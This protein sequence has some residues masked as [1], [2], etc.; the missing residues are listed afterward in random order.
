MLFNSIINVSSVAIHII[1][2]L[3]YMYIVCRKVF[4][5]MHNL[6]LK[7]FF[8]LNRTM[9]VYG[10]FQGIVLNDVLSFTPGNSKHL[11]MISSSFCTLLRVCNDFCFVSCTGK[12]SQNV[13]FYIYL[14]EV[15]SKFHVN[16]H[17]RC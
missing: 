9:Y 7:Q 6:L 4:T 5:Y 8:S 15:N 16:C 14:H 13:A 17:Y 11:K 12:R 10:G 1:V 2:Y 3:Y